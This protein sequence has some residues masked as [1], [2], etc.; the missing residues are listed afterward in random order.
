MAAVTLPTGIELSFHRQGRGGSGAVV[1]LPGPTDSWRSYLPVLSSIP[2]H[3]RVVAVSLRGHGDSSKPS[4]G[5]RVEDLASDVVP[6]LDALAIDRAVL[7]GHSGSCLVSRRVALDAPDRVCGLFLEASPS[8]LRGHEGLRT[9][10]DDV[11]SELT[12]PIDRNV[13]RSLV[14]DTSSDDLGSELVERLVD[15]I[16]AV[17]LQAWKEMFTSLLDYDDTPRLSQIDVPVCLL[18][19]DDDTLVPERM[20]DELARLLRRPERRVYEG[21][22]HTPRWEAP[23]RFARDLTDFSAPLLR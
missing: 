5:Y 2:E 20:Q 23:E 7:V 4:T 21:V 1:M 9:F 15:D 10:V 6:L 18:W 11:V 16:V 12:W 3:L 14:A 8:T 13:A 19:G 17:P 22:G